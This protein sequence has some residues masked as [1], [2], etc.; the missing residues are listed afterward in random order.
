ME[1]LGFIMLYAWI[2]ATAIIAKKV[3]DT[4]SYED[5]VLLFA[6]AAFVLYVIGT[7][8]K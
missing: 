7:I 6:V 1:L 2:H 5:V 3:Q 8:G 4:T